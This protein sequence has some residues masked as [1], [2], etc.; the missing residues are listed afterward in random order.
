MLLLVSLSVLIIGGMSVVP[1]QQGK[2]GVGRSR[3]YHNVH[4]AGRISLGERWP[5]HWALYAYRHL[6]KQ[7]PSCFT[8]KVAS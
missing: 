8:G 6:G 7:I 4:M 2:R 5:P 3:T 1:S